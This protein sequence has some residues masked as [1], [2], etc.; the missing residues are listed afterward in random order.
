MG[1]FLAHVKI[2]SRYNVIECFKDVLF[3]INMFLLL[4]NKFFFQD[5]AFFRKMNSCFWV[6][7][8]KPE[9]I[10]ILSA[11][12]FSSSQRSSLW[13]L[14]I[15]NYHNINRSKPVQCLLVGVLSGKPN[16]RSSAV[17]QLA[18]KNGT[19]AGDLET[20]KKPSHIYL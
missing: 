20:T 15:K 19:T 18:Q 3:D 4:S 17:K 12:H 8:G 11:S 13:S 14:K 16:G 1:M 2:K 7:N 9:A 10:Q 6:I 5:A